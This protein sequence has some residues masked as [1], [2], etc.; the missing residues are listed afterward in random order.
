MAK[1]SSDDQTPYPSRRPPTPDNSKK[2]PQGARTRRPTARGRGVAS[3][4]LT[5]VHRSSRSAAAPES[6]AAAARARPSPRALAS[7]S[8]S[9]QVTGRGAPEARQ[10]GGGDRGGGVEQHDVADRA[11]LAGQHRA[12]HGGVVRPGRRRAGPS[13]DARGRPSA[14]GSNEVT[15]TAPSPAIQTVDGPVVLSSSRRRRRG[16]PGPTPRAR[17]TPRPAPAP[18]RDRRCRPPAT[19]AGPGWSAAPGS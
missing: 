6:T 14:A 8:G 9:E 5:W 19:S 1:P 13:M 7:E 16:T 17:R 15:V 3:R 12:R 11:G 2:R 18:S 4:L 10:P